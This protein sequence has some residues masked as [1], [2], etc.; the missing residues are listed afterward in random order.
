MPVKGL[1]KY[2][3]AAS[4]LFDRHSSHCDLLTLKIESNFIK[5]TWK[6]NGTLRLPWRPQMP[7]VFG[8]T[9]YHID[10]TGLIFLH[11]ETWDNMT[12]IRA[13]FETFLPNKWNQN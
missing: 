1:R 4:Q 6:F 10:A 13:F 11:E 7:V 3:N 12:A 8:T 5:A 9:T 2:Q